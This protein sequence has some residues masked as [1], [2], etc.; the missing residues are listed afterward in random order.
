MPPSALA[1]GSVLQGEFSLEE[2]LGGNVY[3]ARR[4]RD[5]R[6]LAVRVAYPRTPELAADFMALAEAASRVRHPTLASVEAFGRL[7]DGGCYIATELVRGQSLQQWAD[8]IGIPPLAQVVELVRKLC[9]GLQA[10]ARAGVVHDALNPRN[11]RVLGAAK[12]TGTRTPLKL[13]DLGVPALLFEHA[14]DTQALRFM[15]PEQLEVLYR[16]HEPQ[17]FRCSATMNVYSCGSLLYYL[18]TGGP[19]YAGVSVPELLASQAGGRLTPPVRINPQI[20]PGLNAVVV[21]ALAIDPTERFVSVS[22][23]GEALANVGGSVSMHMRSLT[24]PPGPLPRP[25]DAQMQD[26]PPTFKTSRALAPL[27]EQQLADVDSDTPASAADRSLHDKPTLPPTAPPPPAAEPGE[28]RDSVSGVAPIGLFSSSPP[29]QDRR[30]S[31][32]PDATGNSSSGSGTSP[33]STPLAAF[34]QPPASGSGRYDLAAVSARRDSV[35]GAGR[36]SSPTITAMPP[37]GPA[38]D[39]GMGGSPGDN[40][41]GMHLRAQRRSWL[42]VALPSAAAACLLAFFT[43][44]SM[45]APEP[46]AT[47]ATPV[48]V[49]QPP[50]A[51][52]ATQP[53]T[54]Q[55]TA[56]PEPTTAPGAAMNAPAPGEIMEFEASELEPEPRAEAQSASN[57]GSSRESR[58]DHGHHRSS[59]RDSR[60]SRS[61]S[62]SEKAQEAQ[63]AAHETEVAKS[64]SAALPVEP[65]DIDTELEVTPRAKSGAAT[66]SEAR[67][68]MER[69]VVTVAA[70]PAQPVSKPAI[71]VLPLTAKVQIGGVEVHGSLPTSHVK[72]A[73]ERLHSQ[74]KSCY[75][76]SAQVAGHNGFGELIVDVQIDERGRARSPHV[77]G[78][79]LPRLD[80]CVA[81]AVSKLISERVPDTG[82]VVATWKIAFTP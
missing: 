43:V 80:S 35:P 63:K 46:D 74:F 17:T 47:A 69:P 73:V 20:S 34:S 72:R 9:I 21:R 57:T 48:P 36:H 25:N 54:A 28:M 56:V 16:S 64:D 27:L 29:F 26:E 55:P 45:L 81:D 24:P 13:L 31:L 77:R 71:P 76:R 50:S 10:A 79:G 5:G 37:V 42:W 49:V 51:A 40:L 15:A 60:D 4:T 66:T 8:Q 52:R 39:V 7:E 61:A 14:N 65:D 62:S 12:G 18:A 68:P 75:E 2:K 38:N 6:E 44:R 3:R 22:E 33:K 82:T 1:L 41:S 53:Q 67:A 32:P 59:S 78:A 19:P 11:V 23:L 70:V 30:S 58:R